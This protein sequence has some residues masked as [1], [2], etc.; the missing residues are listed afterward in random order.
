MTDLK[1]FFEFSFGRVR[2]LQPNSVNNF[3]NWILS[4]NRNH[5]VFT[6]Q[7]VN[8]NAGKQFVIEF[9][10]SHGQVVNRPPSI[11]EIDKGTGW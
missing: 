3:S 5:E 8:A 6:C 1:K 11:L 2:T 7:T 9:Q 4:F 10:I